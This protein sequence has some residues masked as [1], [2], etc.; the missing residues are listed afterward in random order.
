MLKPN[1]ASNH[2]T[3][4]SCQRPLRKSQ[5]KLIIISLQ[6]ISIANVFENEPKETE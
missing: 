3:P 4:L 5:V 1:V 6:V 2:A